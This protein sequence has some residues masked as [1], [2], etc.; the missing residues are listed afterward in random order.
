MHLIH[1]GPADNKGTQALVLSDISAITDI[2][3][4]P[5]LFSASAGDVEGIRRLDNRLESV[6]P[7]LIDIPYQKADYL[8]RKYGLNRNSL[9]YK[10]F[11]I[12]ILLFMPLQ[13]VLSI[14]SVML[15]K[16]RSKPFYRTCTIK[17]ME[18]CDLVV[19][20]SDEN[21]KES[22]SFLPL[23]L[24]W[25]VS[26]W[27]M[28][29][30]R[31]WDILVARSF[32]KPVVMFPNSVGPFRTW[33]G[34]SL[35][36][37]SL[38]SCACVLVRD[39]ISYRII[40]SLKIKCNKL[41]TADTALLFRC[42]GKLSL[43]KE[44]GPL[45]GVSPG[46]YGHSLSEM[47]VCNYVLAHAQSLDL[48]VK[49]YGFRIFLLPNFV[50]GFAHDDLEICKRIKSNMANEDRVEIVLAN[51]V[52]EF[53]AF[54]N[55]MDMI[56]TSKMHPAILAASEYVPTLCIAYDHKQTGFFERLGM[57]DC[58]IDIRK[59]S[60]AVLSSKIDYVW[61]NRDKIRS[62][63]K[64]QIP[65]LQENIRMAIRRAITPFVRNTLVEDP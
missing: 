2:V 64:E 24:F 63:L 31:T 40:N 22:A 39:P 45:I 34:R 65:V 38:V 52:D 14:V 10:A 19:S 54:L 25:I 47:E 57:A 56:V 46:V 58:T 21:L 28:L 42:T 41:L 32:K 7:P 8:A 51:T 12:A 18:Q 50:M 9:E 48:A 20:Y 44:Q 60:Y 5:V 23:N 62:S 49:K 13:A 3:N 15:V 55:E 36:R 11:A 30:S 26:W 4:R 16:S 35:A 33:I 53:K 17:N 59:V 29:F 1:V 6:F 27:S 43:N 37:L 61:S